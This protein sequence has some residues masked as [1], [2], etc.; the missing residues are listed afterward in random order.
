MSRRTDRVS[1]LVRAE[2]ARILRQETTDPRLRL[3]TVTHVRVSPISVTR[4]STGAVSPGTTSRTWSALQRPSTVPAATCV[5]TSRRRFPCDERRPFAFATTPPWHSG[6]GPWPP[7]A[8]CRMSRRSRRRSLEQP[9]PSG[10]LV[11]DKPAGWTSHDVVDAARAWWGTR[12]VGHLGTPRSSRDRR[13]A[14]RRARCHQAD[15]LP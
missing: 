14:P 7:C 1:Q 4:R 6:P 9:G 12:R 15:P 3:V 11:V 13:V 5:A 10:F 8:G 2:V